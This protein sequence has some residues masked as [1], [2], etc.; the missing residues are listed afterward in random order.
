MVVYLLKANKL[1]CG[2]FFSNCGK[3][4]AFNTLNSL[5]CV[6][7]GQYCLLQGHTIQSKPVGILDTTGFGFGFSLVDLSYHKAAYKMPRSGSGLKLWHCSDI[8]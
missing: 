6:S 7:V 3:M 4:I 1:L 8:V 5:N 2:I